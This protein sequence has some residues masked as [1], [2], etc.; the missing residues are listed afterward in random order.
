ML[1]L[2]TE[3]GKPGR[4]ERERRHFARCYNQDSDS[5]VKPRGRRYIPHGYGDDGDWR[6]HPVHLDVR[7]TEC[8]PDWKSRPRRIPSPNEISYRPE[9]W[10]NSWYNMRCYPY[11][12]AGTTRSGNEWILYPERKG[13]DA[14]LRSSW[15]GQHKATATSHD[16]LTH[17]M[18]FGRGRNVAVIDKRNGIAQASP[19]DKNYQ[20]VEYSRHFH[21]EGSTLPVVHFGGS[22][23]ATPDTFVPL[24]ELP[25]IPRANYEKKERERRMEEERND[26]RDLDVWRPATPLVQPGPAPILEDRAMSQTSR[27]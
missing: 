15:E 1:H 27:N 18:R 20:A 2:I 22:K 24:Q 25:P 17:Q 8:G 26:V 4:N 6:P 11:L 23:R 5:E 7:Y 10:P 19:G 14:T 12:P 13:Y 21:K 3:I 9:I 16:E